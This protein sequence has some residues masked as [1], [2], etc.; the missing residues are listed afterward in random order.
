MTL[1]ASWKAAPRSSAHSLAT[2]L[3]PTCKTVALKISDNGRAGAVR[4]FPFANEL[5][6]RNP[7][8]RILPWDLRSVHQACGARE[9]S[10]AGL[11]FQ[12]GDGRGGVDGFVVDSVYSSR[13][14]AAFARHR[15]AN[16]ET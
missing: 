16:V 9:R 15:P 5:G 3:L 1:R 2:T 13:L 7:R 4:P 8:V 14:S 6:H 11:V 10:D 12:H